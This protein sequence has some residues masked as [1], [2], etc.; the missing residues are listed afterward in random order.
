MYYYRKEQKKQLVSMAKHGNGKSTVL[1]RGA[2]VQ[3][4]TFSRMH[5]VLADLLFPADDV[6]GGSVAKLRVMYSSQE[7]QM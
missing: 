1:S 6:K 2:Y 4:N 3:H 5:F 7:D